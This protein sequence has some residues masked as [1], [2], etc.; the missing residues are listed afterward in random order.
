MKQSYRTKLYY[1]MASEYY[2]DGIMVAEQQSWLFW[3]FYN[4]ACQSLKEDF[5]RA[6]LNN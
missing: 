3:L 2:D 1:E 6:R 5:R 4:E